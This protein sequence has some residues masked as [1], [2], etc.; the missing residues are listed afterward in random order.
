MCRFI[1]LCVL[2]ALLN[3]AA[4]QPFVVTDPKFV[5]RQ[6]AKPP[7]VVAV[8]RLPDG[9][10]AVGEIHISR[11]SLSLESAFEEA[12]Q[13]GQ[14]MGCEFVFQ[15]E[16]VAGSAP[17]VGAAGLG[18]G[19]GGVAAIRAAEEGRFWCAVDDYA[20]RSQT[21]EPQ[22]GASSSPGGGGSSP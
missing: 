6:A 9:F 11:F 14:Q 1:L 20:A 15:V 13:T 3:C 5:P 4:R 21:A 16:S 17:T 22:K 12:A 7:R 18:P 10:R 2:G 19:G 8:T